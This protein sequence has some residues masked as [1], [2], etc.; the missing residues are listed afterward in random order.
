M[1]SPTLGWSVP[2]TINTPAV[3]DNF[4]LKAQIKIKGNRPIEDITLT[5]FDVPTGVDFSEI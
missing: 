2:E 3:V 4:K 5:F 1:Y